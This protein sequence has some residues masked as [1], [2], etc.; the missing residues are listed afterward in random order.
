MRHLPQGQGLQVRRRLL[1]VSIVWAWCLIGSVWWLASAGGAARGS[2]LG[3]SSSVLAST[4]C[5]H[6]RRWL[7]HSAGGYAW[8]MISPAPGVG[9]LA[10]LCPFS[11]RRIFCRADLFGGELARLL[12]TRAGRGR[13]SGFVPFASVADGRR[14]SIVA[15]F[16]GHGVGGGMLHNLHGTAGSGNAL[17][18]AGRGGPPR[19]GGGGGGGTRPCSRQISVSGPYTRLCLVETQTTCCPPRRVKH[20]SLRLPTPVVES[21]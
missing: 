11:R 21:M 9:A 7:V 10:V 20:P 1:C 12:C 18:A 15:S 6:V 3:V 13:L 17:S 5:E 19:S 4:V 2:G 8:G 14:S 16:T